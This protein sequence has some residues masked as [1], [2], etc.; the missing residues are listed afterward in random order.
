MLDDLA[1]E[2]VGEALAGL[3]ATGRQVH[4]REQSF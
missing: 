3:L 1:L 4:A 2:E